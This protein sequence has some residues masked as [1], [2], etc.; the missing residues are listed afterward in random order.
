MNLGHAELVIVEAEGTHG[1]EFLH[2]SEER[3]YLQRALPTDETR[4]PVCFSS[5]ACDA[6][7][8]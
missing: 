3:R 8:S 4:L 1:C 6:R 5:P 7:N 2:S